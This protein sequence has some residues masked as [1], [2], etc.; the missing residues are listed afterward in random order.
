MPEFD[1]RRPI[2]D[3][4]DEPMTPHPTTGSKAARP[5]AV[6]VADPND[7]RRE[8]RRTGHD[9]A[10]QVY[11]RSASASGSQRR[12]DAPPRRPAIDERDETPVTQVEY[13]LIGERQQ[14]LIES[15]RHVLPTWGVKPHECGIGLRN[16][17]ETLS[18]RPD[19]GL[20]LIEPTRGLLTAL[21]EQPHLMQRRSIVVVA[22]IDPPRFYL[23][24]AL[25]I[26][27]GGILLSTCPLA[28]LLAAI[29]AVRV[30]GRF[31]SPALQGELKLDSRGRIGLT[32]RDDLMSL[33]GRQLEVVRL[34]AIGCSTKDIAERLSL[35]PK[36]IESHRYRAMQRLGVHDRIE[37]TRI[38]LSEGL[39]R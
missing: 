29:D 4:A 15:F 39:L 26:A 7:V 6:H 20:L 19:S 12:L 25:R 37:L 10:P 21:R 5:D 16:L 36:T 35:S 3:F 27:P 32:A 1:P 34:T 23:R 38:A 13:V 14:M 18:S 9:A 33:T 28:V 24:D 22:P 2:G 8:S 31:I 11:L 30:D 17:T